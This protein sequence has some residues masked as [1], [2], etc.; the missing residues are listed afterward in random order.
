[1]VS[2]V[3]RPVSPS[4]TCSTAESVAVQPL[5]VGLGGSEGGNA[6]A[7]DHWKAQ[8]DRFINQG[9]AFLAIG[10]FG[11]EG[12][13]EHLDRISLDAIRDAAV[14]AVA[15]P[16]VADD[17]F[18]VIGGSRGA[19]AALLL[20]SHFPEVTAVV[21]IV[22]G[23]AVFPALNYAMTTAGFSLAGEPLA[24]VPVPWGAAPELLM[25][26][27]HGAFEDMRANRDAVAQAV[28]AVERING[29]VL[30]VSATRDE[31]W[32]STEMSEAMMQRLD[33]HG[34]PHAAQHIAIEGGHS[35]PFEHFD[36]IEAFLADHYPASEL[37][38]ARPCGRTDE[39]I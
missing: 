32:A 21:A 1:M 19:E 26:D 30:F 4:V 35:A 31:M 14:E 11:M 38:T 29:P 12:T 10:Y 28:I 15:H 9:Y 25:G 22:P 8:R 3:K 5:I 33:A 24:F 17:C 37:T 34:F 2:S 6:W 18:A 36:R 7:S 16:D 39:T 13:P 20:G 23:N 27:L